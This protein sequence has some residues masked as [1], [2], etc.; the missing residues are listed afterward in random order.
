MAKDRSPDWRRQL[1]Y[2]LL[3]DRFS[4]T[5]PGRPALDAANPHPLPPDALTKE[6]YWNLWAISGRNRFQGGTIKGIT[7]RL[8]YLEGLGVT[9]LWIGTVWKQRAAGVDANAN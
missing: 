6:W 2:F 7:S 5:V 9:V 8:D 1:I 3:P 4:D